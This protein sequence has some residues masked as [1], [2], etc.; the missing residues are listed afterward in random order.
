MS[1]YDILI[2]NGRIVDGTGNPWYNADIGILDGKIAKIGK[3]P[4]DAETVIDAGGNIVAPGF[5]DIHSHMD[6]YLIHDPLGSPKLW[7]GV[8]TETLA[9]CGL[10]PAPVRKENIDVLKFCLEEILG[11]F[12]IRWDWSTIGEYL[13]RLGKKLG[14]NACFHAGHIPIRLEVMGGVDRKADP[15]DIEAMK[16]LVEEGMDHGA[17]GFSTGLTYHPAAYAN[18]S[19]VIELAKVA[20]SR[21]G[22]ISLHQRQWG[23]GFRDS[24]KEAVRIGKE[25]SIPLQFSHLVATRSD[26]TV[27][28]AIEYF[29]QARE[30]GVDITYEVIPDFETVWLLRTYLPDWIRDGEDFEEIK[31]RLGDREIRE[32]LT[33]D[34]KSGDCPY[35]FSEWNE[36]TVGDSGTERY[37]GMTISE[38]ASDTDKEP[39][40]AF[41]DLLI[42]DELGTLIRGKVNSY[43]DLV[44]L[45][46]DRHCGVGSDA[47]LFERGNYSLWQ[48]AFANALGYFVR[49]KKVIS[50]EEMVRKITSF[51]AMKLRLGD[52]GMVMEG[53]AADLVVFD[54]R[55]IK[56]TA[57]LEKPGIAEGVETVIVNGVPVLED[58]EH[59]GAYPGKLLRRQAPEGE[60]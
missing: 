28:W 50:L 7:Q 14:I 1:T 4:F 25:A 9:L 37:I 59:T 45:L 6:L 42:G 39:V 10:A 54:P 5:I 2:K 31:G 3:G 34:F 21:G 18:T 23:H 57:T 41:C 15:Q 29:R 17:I 8:T 27:E 58:G 43:E 60:N 55:S 36:I 16:A 53:M 51:P 52:R 49:D 26:F 30:N 38:I 13:E 35:P 56:S 20:S 44:K 40:D 19:E 24:M 46:R 47:F 11:D 22:I 12:S 48:G 33:K 32:R